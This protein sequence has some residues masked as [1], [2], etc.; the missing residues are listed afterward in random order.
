M[1]IVTMVLGESGSGKTFSTKNL[2]PKLTT[3]IKTIDK[4]PSFRQTEVPTTF[5]NNHAR[6]IVGILKKSQRPIIVIDDFQY[7]MSLNYSYSTTKGFEKFNEI[8]TGFLDIVLTAVNGMKPYQR[9]YILS[10]IQE[11]EGKTKMKTLGKFIDEKITPEGLVTIVLQTKIENNQNQ[12]LT[13][14]DGNTTVK[15]PFEMFDDDL[16]PNDLQLVDNA[17]CDYYQIPKNPLTNGETA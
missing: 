13:R 10:H 14:N 12:F 7:F 3:L 8:N 5:I 2:D 15:T 9:V 11:T 16:I 1:A 17:I 6:D 4:P